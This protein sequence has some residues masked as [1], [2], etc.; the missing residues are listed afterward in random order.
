MDKICVTHGKIACEVLECNFSWRKIQRKVDT[1]EV[2][3]TLCVT[4]S[5]IACRG[6]PASQLTDSVLN[7]YFPGHISSLLVHEL[8]AV[9]TGYQMVEFYRTFFL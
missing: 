6:L 7:A 2:G 4:A 5:G 9:H 8:L 1:I 3:H